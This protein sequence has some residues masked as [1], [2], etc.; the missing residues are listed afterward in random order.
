MVLLNSIYLKEYKAQLPRPVQGTCTWVL[1]DPA[2]MAWVRA[3][4]TRLLWVTGEPGC[5]KTVLSAYLSDHLR[6]NHST[7]SKPQVFFFFCDD[8]IKSQRD[9]NAI[10]RGILYQILQQHRKLIRHVK[11][12][13]ELDGPSLANSFPALW[14]LFLKV[15]ADSTTGTVGIIVDAIDEC[16]ARTR[17]SFL[18]AMN[19]LVNERKNKHQQGRNCIK[20]LIT[21]RPSLSN[22]HHLTEFMDNKLSIGQNQVVVS[23]DVKLVI[24]SRVGEITKKFQCNDEMKH[25]LEE[26]LYTKA[27]QSFLWLSLVL[28]SLESSPRASKRDFERIINTFPQNLEATYSKFLSVIPHRD[29]EDAGK[30][31]RLL[32]GA[33]RHLT[34]TELNIAFTVDQNH[35]STA[36]V[37]DDLQL[38]IRSTL[39]DIVGSFIRIKELD[40]SSKDDPIVSLIHQS[41]KEYLTDLALHSTDMVVQSLAVP[42][43]QAALSMA[44]SCIRYL[45][46]EDFKVDL[47]ASERASMESCS[48]KSSHFLPFTDSEVMEWDGPLGLSDHLGLESFFKDSRDLEE[49]RCT[50]IAQEHRFFD[51]AAIH[52][53]EHYSFCGGAASMSIRE[54]VRQLTASSSC[55]LTNWLKYYWIKNNI[56]YSFPDAFETIEVAAF[57]NLATLLAEVMGD[58]D[59]RSEAKVRALFWAA[60]MSSPECIK[61]LLQH[62]TDPNRISIGR[63]TP[64]IVSA[65]YG[66]LDAV[67]VFLEEPNTDISIKGKSGRSALSFAAGN[68]HLEIVNALLEKGAF[69]PDDHDNTHWTPLFWAVQGDYAGIVQLLLKQPSIN[70]NQVDKSGRSVLS[71]AAGEGAQRTLKILLKQ[72]SIDLNLND[73]QDRSPLSWAAGNGQREVTSILMH[74]T[75]VDKSTKDKDKRNAISWACQ[76]GHTDT[77]RTLLKY[78]CDGVDD[79]DVDAWTPLLWSLFI[80]S[81]ATVEALLSTRRVQ[82]DRQDSY[83]RTALIWA[84]SYGYLDVVQLL[85]LW[86]AALHIKNNRG[87]AAAEVARLE[88]QIEVWEF[89]E[90]QQ[91]KEVEMPPE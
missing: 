79:V 21:S 90:A 64:F 15:A 58:T 42:P 17:N 74:K 63:Q 61:L 22:S 9:A 12:R 20:F 85:V 51:Y 66:H 18:N 38:S 84:A 86:N 25:Y 69:S 54:A 91:D 77:L 34:L 1:S 47:F 3:E 24:R 67:Q 83:G 39:Q 45:L 29:R 4:E 44:Q 49:A 80:R 76:G 60:R 30:F 75:G 65:Q 50:V 37:A 5:G 73:E 87:H 7:A 88:G 23:E 68:G 59:I 89:L 57:F 46:I 36:D 11:S 32:I 6:L 82:I 16:E 52:W 33:S 10:L 48:P 19:Q 43:V 72:P 55:V 27:D 56:E 8:K 53:A 26:K 70:V 81:P 14:E 2:Y 28:Q 35:K 40:R 71:W 13:F 78:G 62:G 41:A 31:L